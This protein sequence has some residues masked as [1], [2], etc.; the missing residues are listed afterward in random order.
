MAQ[1]T[2]RNHA[3][4]GHHKQ[5]VPLTCQYPQRYVVPAVVVTQSKPVP[6]TAARPVS[7]DV[8]KIEVTRPRHA[9]P[10]VAKTN[11]PTRIHI[12]RSPSPKARNSPSRVTAVKAL[13]VKLQAI[14]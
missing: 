10:I 1:P 14:L 8:P 2:A 3:H 6:L 11:S 9:K 4:R 12:T 5:Y 7:T 13:L